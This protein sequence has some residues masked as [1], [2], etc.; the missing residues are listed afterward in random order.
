M[1]EAQDSLLEDMGVPVADAPEPAHMKLALFVFRARPQSRV[2]M[3]LSETG[4]TPTRRRRRRL[5]G[6]RTRAS[7]PTEWIPTASVPSGA[8]MTTVGASRRRWT[9]SPPGAG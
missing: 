5:G 1:P 7:I 3:G 4:G 8:V 2:S 9:G 6:Q